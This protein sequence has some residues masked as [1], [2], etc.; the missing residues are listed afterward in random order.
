MIESWGRGTIKILN[1]CVNAGLPEPVFREEF[2]GFSVSFFKGSEEKKVTEKVTENQKKI[3]EAVSKNS[4]ISIKEL[5]V[6]VG[7]SSR[8]IQD[9]INKLRAKRLLKR[10]GSARAGKWMLNGQD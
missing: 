6:I 10:V 8:K 9:N 7:I 3:L 2:G 1:E 4:A 5:S